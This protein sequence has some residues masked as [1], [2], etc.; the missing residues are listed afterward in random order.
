MKKLFK[1][2]LFSVLISFLFAPA[3]MAVSFGDN[4]WFW[5]N[6]SPEEWNNNDSDAYGDQKDVIG[7]PNINGFGYSSSGGQATFS[8]NLLQQISFTMLTGIYDEILA[9]GDLFLSTDGDA[10]NW[11]YIVDI[12]TWSASGPSVADPN[13]GSQYRI[14]SGLNVALGSY[15]G[16]TAAEK[17]NFATT[18]YI[19]S[20]A[21]RASPWGSYYIRD[22]QPVAYNI[23]Y[24]AWNSGEEGVV[25]NGW[26]T[27]AGIVSFDFTSMT[28]GGINVDDGA[29][30]TIGWTV[31]CAND[32]IYETVAPS[33]VVVPEPATMF[34][35]GAGL[36]GLAGISR[37]RFK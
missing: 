19:L 34:L 11:E 14:Y 22:Y 24:D 8:G 10:S 17:T 3:A 29:N 28:G 35:L 23:G 37:R 9:P 15:A 2:V 6:S 26:E 13:N 33:G 27:D 21:D 12:T 1:V 7:D 25:F 18:D 30:L 5:G 20:G 4:H 16:L 36:I 32:V 31:N